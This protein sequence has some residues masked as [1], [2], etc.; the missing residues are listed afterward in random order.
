[1]RPTNDCAASLAGARGADDPKQVEQRG[2]VI[3]DAD[4]PQFRNRRAFLIWA[5]MIGVVPPERV[6]ERVVAEVESEVAT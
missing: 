2:N 6:V 5:C 3:A 4:P 1:M